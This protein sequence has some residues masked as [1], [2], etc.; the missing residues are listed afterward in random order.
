MKN[1]EGLLKEYRTTFEDTKGAGYTASEAQEIY[2]LAQDQAKK[3]G[4][5]TPQGLIYCSLDIAWSVAY[6]TGYK[7]G[8]KAAKSESK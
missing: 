4:E 8:L 7:K 1:I 6:M 2:K 3:Y 5:T